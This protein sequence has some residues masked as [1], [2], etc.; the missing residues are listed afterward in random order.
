MSLNKIS[1]EDLELMSY[2]DIAEIIL[3]EQKQTLTPDLFRKIVELLELPSSAFESKI[4]DFYTSMS[5][6]KRF[7]LIDGAWDLKT[8]HV[9]KP[10]FIDEE[11]DDDIDLEEFEDKE[12]DMEEDSEDNYGDE[13]TDTGEDEFK[14]LVIIDE[15]DLELEQ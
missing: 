15:E 8:R 14:N 12:E 13:D 10:M 2:T 7:V 4:G 6:D 9:V 11:D 5:T 3:E 1:K